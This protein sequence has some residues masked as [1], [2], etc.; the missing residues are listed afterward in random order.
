MTSAYSS[1]RYALWHHESPLIKEP[2]EWRTTPKSKDV[3]AL[4]APVR[5]QG[6][7]RVTEPAGA[8]CLQVQLTQPQ[9]EEVAHWTSQMPEHVMRTTAELQGTISHEGAYVCLDSTYCSTSR[10]PQADDLVAIRI[11]PEVVRIG[12]LRKAQIR[13]TDVL[14]PDIAS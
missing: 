7:V 4:V 9:A 13:I 10:L 8:N 3:V 6:H 1:S 5:L 14:L 11:V 12:P 2:V